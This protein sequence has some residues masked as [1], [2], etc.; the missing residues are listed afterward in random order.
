MGGKYRGPGMR[1]AP[2]RLVKAVHATAQL[3]VPHGAAEAR[4]PRPIAPLRPAV[5]RIPEAASPPAP[6]EPSTGAAEDGG[7]LRNGRETRRGE[8]T[9][10][11]RVRRGRGRSGCERLRAYADGSACCGRSG[12]AVASGVGAAA[13]PNADDAGAVR[14]CGRSHLMHTSALSCTPASRTDAQD[15]YACVL[16]GCVGGE[17]ALR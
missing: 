13:A 3:Q 2:H 4:R 9:R 16:A 14:T 12:P 15:R 5:R 10:A 11:R 8:A 7:A 6:T 1:R 17:R